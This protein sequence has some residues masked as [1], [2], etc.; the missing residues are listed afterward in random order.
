MKYLNTLYKY[1]LLRVKKLGSLFKRNID[2]P[3]TPP[4]QIKRVKKKPKQTRSK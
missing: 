3:S 2:K 1:F 4:V